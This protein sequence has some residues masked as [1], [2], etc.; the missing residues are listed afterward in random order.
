MESTF[1]KGQLTIVV[2]RAIPYVV[3][4]FSQ[5]GR[6]VALKST[7]ITRKAL[8]KTDILIVR[9]ETRV[10]KSLLEGS[11]IRFVGT[12]TIGTDHIDPD[13]LVSKGIAFASAPGSNANS[14]AEYVAAGLLTWTE[15]TRQ[16]LQ[17]K[18]IGIVGVGNVGSKVLNVAQALGMTPLLND[19][20][21]ARRH[22][23]GKFVPLDD[24]MDADF[25]TLHVPL[26]RT[27]EDATV[28]LFDKKRIAGMKR[29]SVL[30]NTSRGPVLETGALREALASSHLSA[31]ILDVWEREPV[32]DMGLLEQ[33]ML[34]T[35][36]IA[37][38]SL[39]GKLNALR[40]VYE[41]V[42]RHLNILPSWTVEAVAPGDL[43]HFRIL[44]H[45][46]DEQAIV[47][48]AVRRA[49]DIELDDSLLRAALNISRDDLGE[50]FMRLR[51]EYR[52][53]RE[54]FNYEIELDS[55]RRTSTGALGQLG[56]KTTVKE[57]VQL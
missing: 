5:I 47:G 2:D 56:F 11:N 48:F 24:L 50:Y 18:T 43:S 13:Y 42:C 52:A 22:V 29:G 55:V 12:V 10:D 41:S 30:I 49:Y 28:H 17:G 20:P 38:Y 39:D 4:A 54:F 1:G 27:G 35:P 51:A 15:R 23:A 21:L 45:L 16:S 14:V 9:S 37:G 53:R 6:V 40:M 34:G 33:V 25:I 46:S 57:K 8:R 3:V 44:A 19:P 32:I 31:A 7:E 36:H 26:T